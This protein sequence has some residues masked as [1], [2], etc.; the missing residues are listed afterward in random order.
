MK[1]QPKT[2]ARGLLAGLIA[3]V[4]FASVAISMTAGG[5]AAPAPLPAAVT[6]TAAVALPQAT[7]AAAPGAVAPAA[8]QLVVPAQGDGEDV[9]RFGPGGGL[10]DFGGLRGDG[11]TA[12]DTRLEPGPR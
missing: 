7:V 12:P 11:P 2:P 9:R 8:P 10:A 3:L 5:S 4:I 1:T 6:Q